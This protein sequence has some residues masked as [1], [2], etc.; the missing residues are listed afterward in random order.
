MLEITKLKIIAVEGRDEDNF[1]SALFDYLGISDIQIIIF[2]G[3]T[4]YKKRIKSITKVS[5]FSK[6]QSF[7]LTRDADNNPPLSA[8]ESI[9]NSLKQ[10]GLPIPE[11]LNEFTET[12]PSVGVFIMPGNSKEGMLEDL[13]LQSIEKFPVIDCIDSFIDCSE[14]KPS[15]ESKAKIMCYLATKGPSSSSL[16][17]A[18]KQGVWDFDSESFTELKEFI[19]NI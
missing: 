10:A 19:L 8:F 14:E 7:A 18:A 11:S 1:F 12:N 13:C 17:L 2:E 15:N 3:K 5:G 6:V 16:G 9:K 4:N